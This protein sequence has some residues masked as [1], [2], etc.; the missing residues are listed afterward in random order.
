MGDGDGARFDAV[1]R[2][3]VSGS[4]SSVERASAPSARDGD[5]TATRMVWCIDKN[6]VRVCMVRC[7]RARGL[8]ECGT[9]GDEGEGDARAK[10]EG[11]D[12]SA[13]RDGAG[14]RGGSGGFLRRRR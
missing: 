4:A 12:A 14:V 11:G 2:R 9:L 1:S 5:A 13:A 3:V 10:G 6:G 7:A 8:D